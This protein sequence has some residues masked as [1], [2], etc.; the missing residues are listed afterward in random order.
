M[1][2]NLLTVGLL[3]LVFTAHAQVLTYVGDGAKFYVSSGA[4]VYSGGD[5][6]V[7]SA[8][9]QTVENK[10][11]IIIVGDYKKGTTVANAA[12]DG[13]EFLNVYTSQ[14]DYG[15]VIIQNTA[16]ATDAR[17]TVQRPAAPSA[18]YNGSF[19]ISF[20]YKDAAT[21]L[22]KSFGKNESDFIGTCALN[23]NCG[24][25]FYNMSLHKWN[26][27]KVHNDPIQ[28][29]VPIV[30]G[31]YYLLNL[32]KGDMQS[33]MTGIVGYKGM[34]SPGTYIAKG[35]SIIPN[36]TEAQF[37]DFTYDQWRTK[38]NPYNEEYQ[39][40]MG[41]VSSASKTY[42]KNIYRFGNPYTSNL[43]L[44][45]FDG[46]NA[47]L[48]IMN[49]GGPRTIKG[50]TDA[51]MIKD[52]Y[53]SKRTQAY[54]VIWNP[55]T[56][57]TNANADY[58]KAMYN[59]TTWVGSP[60]ALLIRPFETF[61]LNF[62]QVNPTTL[63]ATRVV[64]VEVSF[65]DSQ[66]TFEYAPGITPQAGTVPYGKMVSNSVSTDSRS[67][68]SASAA[69][70]NIN[71]FYQAEIFL[72]ENNTIIEQPVYL[73]GANYE[74]ESADAAVS[75]R[76]LFVLGNTNGQVVSTS[77][78]DF[79]T[80]NS[81]DYVA[82]PLG[83][84]F[85]DLKV[86][87]TYELRFNLYEGSIFNRVKNLSDAKFYIFDS[88]S[89]KSEIVNADKSFSFTINSDADLQSL[90]NR[91]VMFWQ[92]VPEGTLGQENVDLNNGKTI[93]YR[94]SDLRKVKFEKVANKASLE[95]YDMSGRL[96]NSAS[97]VSTS[98]DY[99]LPLTSQGVFVVKVTY[100]NGEVRTL[101]ATK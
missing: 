94:D 28:V 68:K 27:S 31:D 2:K 34:P 35:K 63:G 88:A 87:S 72:I 7:N 8:V 98:S 10:G 57:S 74:K 13:Q 37:S 38:V 54:D 4:L 48:K 19:P 39:S 89:N 1:K 81:V 80:F 96:L 6:A 42:A 71:G 99:V 53:V 17:M 23:A 92:N 70:S 22:M 84:G 58:V 16:S 100:D 86:G 46:T 73:V 30:A 82:K 78:K 14:N 45:A 79:N 59:G 32:R 9:A 41:R 47:W 95:I 76:K 24:P 52:F 5:M 62:A 55:S 18:Y 101:K 15:Q 97:N 66:K 3:L 61:N 36:F 51:Q 56:G 40:Y 12:T 26:N 25:N 50:A 83:L 77:Q 11:N 64:D 69:V 49:A 93:V 20:P 90:S 44:S 21:Y 85:K 67:A 65:N 33:V 60:E 91:F 75:N 29:G 43:D